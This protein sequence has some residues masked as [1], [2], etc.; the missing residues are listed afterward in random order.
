MTT[1]RIRDC[2]TKYDSEEWT[3]CR[4]MILNNA[5]HSWGYCQCSN[6]TR[7]FT[8]N[9]HISAKHSSQMRQIQGFVEHSSEKATQEEAGKP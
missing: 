4:K 3:L 8:R 9:A 2:A 6:C 1:V 5:R 7:D